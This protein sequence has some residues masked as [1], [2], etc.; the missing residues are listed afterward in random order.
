MKNVTDT[1]EIFLSSPGPSEF[2]NKLFFL[3]AFDLGKYTT[4]AVYM[5]TKSY[6]NLGTPNIATASVQHKLNKSATSHDVSAQKLPMA[7]TQDPWDLAD[8]Q[9]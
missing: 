2:P 8:S 6:K 3:S 7:G 1:S 5:E 9:T 4:I